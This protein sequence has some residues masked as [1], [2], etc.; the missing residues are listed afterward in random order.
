MS[1]EQT[2]SGEGTATRYQ[3]RIRFALQHPDMP[4]TLTTF[5]IEQLS[6]H[7][8]IRLSRIWQKNAD[9]YTDEGDE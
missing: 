5:E 3:Q 6:K 1:R 2:M 4:L 7:I 8:A 9:R